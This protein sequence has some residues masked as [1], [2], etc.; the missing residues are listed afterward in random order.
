MELVDDQYKHLILALK[1]WAM[2]RTMSTACVG[3]GLAGRD[4]FKMSTIQLYKK[5]EV[6]RT[7]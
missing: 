7:V 2:Y 4:Q 1:I 6:F 3:A 5:M